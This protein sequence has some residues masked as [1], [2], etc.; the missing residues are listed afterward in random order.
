M[1]VACYAI[2]AET[3]AMLT[4]QQEQL[5]INFVRALTDAKVTPGQVAAACDVTE[6][7]VSNWKRTGKIA[8]NNLAKI[9]DLTGW[10]VQELLSGRSSAS[11]AQRTVFDALTDEEQDLLNDLRVL[12]DEDR[13][14]V[15][16]LVAV[17]AKKARAY[18]QALSQ[19]KGLNLVAQPAKRATAAT[20]TIAVTGKLKQRS[21]LDD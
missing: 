13:D 7:A 6:Q 4:E 9:A 15:R 2:P 8:A 14:E 12:I 5:R 18:M 11:V 21:L 19:A 17:K 3:Q 16:A 1:L 10:S 20:A